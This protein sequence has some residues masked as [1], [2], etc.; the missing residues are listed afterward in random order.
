ML[1]KKHHIKHKYSFSW[2]RQLCMLSVLVLMMPLLLFF[3]LLYKFVI[4]QTRYMIISGRQPGEISGVQR[5]QNGPIQRSKDFPETINS[6]RYFIII[7]SFSVNAYNVSAFVK[8]DF[9]LFA[10]VVSN[11]VSTTFQLH[12]GNQLS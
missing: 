8:A 12:I 11:S 1:A 5:V 3:L 10:Q 6:S 2:K 9:F 7:H 4:S